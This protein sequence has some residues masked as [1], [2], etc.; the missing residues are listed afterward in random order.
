M[1]RRD[2]TLFRLHIIKREYDAPQY[3]F[4]I[5]TVDHASLTRTLDV[6]L[7]RTLWTFRWLR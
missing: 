7:Y 4:L 5:W 1:K 2:W 6:W 3:G